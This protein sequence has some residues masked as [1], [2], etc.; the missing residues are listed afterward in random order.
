MDSQFLDPG[1]AWLPV[2]GGAAVFL[3]MLLGDPSMLP[4]PV[5]LVGN[6]AQAV[7]S[8]MR[9]I[10][11]QVRQV[12]RS[13]ALRRAGGAAVVIVVAMSGAAAWAL[14][15][16]PTF[17]PLFALYLAY[18]GLALGALLREGRIVRH[19]LFVERDLLAARAALGMLV[20]RETR[21][22]DRQGV[23]RGLAETISENANDGFVAPFFWF[24]L[25]GVAG[26]GP[27]WAVASLWAFK[28]VSTLDSMWGYKTKKWK[29]FG[30]AAARLDDILAWLPARIAAMAM[31]LTA[32]AERR[33]ALKDL[34]TLWASIARDAKTTASPNAGWPMSAAAW[35]ACAWVGG[36][37]VYFGK[38]KEKPTLGPEQN[39]WTEERMLTLFSLVRSSCIG[40]AAAML[41]LGFC[42][43]VVR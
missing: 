29:D 40:A 39:E 30:Y 35:L 9:Q 43:L 10:A 19:R 8:G 26:G 1:I 5:R 32:V 34:R 2:L 18:A 6:V 4:H 16:M 27:E 36:P 13:Q 24:T 33:L 31:L 7:E 17:G 41:A 25:G 15:S 22:L 42:L 11:G 14:A 3:D 23:M 12:K 28:A 21:D 37:A 38:R 20:S